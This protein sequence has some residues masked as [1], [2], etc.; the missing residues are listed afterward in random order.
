MQCVYLSVRLFSAPFC[1]TF[2]PKPQA[3]LERVRPE[4]ASS[5]GNRADIIIE[6]TA[7]AL[8]QTQ[9]ATQRDLAVSLLNRETTMYRRGGG[10]L[11]PREK[12]TNRGCRSCGEGIRRERGGAWAGGGGFPPLPGG[13][14]AGHTR[15]RA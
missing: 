8:D 2:V 1:P 4:R 15:P 3:T 12:R 9:S 7:D 10:G 5:A 14:G 11:Q 6:Q 13:A